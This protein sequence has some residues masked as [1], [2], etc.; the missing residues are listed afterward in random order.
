[1][2]RFKFLQHRKTEELYAYSIDP[3]ALNDLIENPSY[4]AVADEL[5]TELEEWM[6]RTGDYVLPALQK[7]ENAAAMSSLWDSW[8]ELASER[9]KDTEW[10]R[11]RNM[12]GPTGGA[13]KYYKP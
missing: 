7:R 3:D 6:E 13:R 2:L 5:R 8:Q 4:A 1:M 10:K 11:W 12:H 9:A